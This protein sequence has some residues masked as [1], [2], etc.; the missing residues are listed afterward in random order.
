[1]QTC[2][3][4]F[5]LDFLF[6]GES[7]ATITYSTLRNFITSSQYEKLNTIPAFQ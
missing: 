3:L 7:T 2:V 4:K 1:M 6:Y 5:G